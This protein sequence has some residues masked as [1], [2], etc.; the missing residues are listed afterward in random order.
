VQDNGQNKEPPADGIR[1]KV[2]I[3]KGGDSMNRLWKKQGR[4][5]RGCWGVWIDKIKKK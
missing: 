5:G 3:G 1:E 4:I 2:V